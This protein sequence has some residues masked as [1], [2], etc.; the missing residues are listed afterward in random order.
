[1]GLIST[2]GQREREVKGGPQESSRVIRSQESVYA[3]ER[4]R[5]LR[6]VSAVKLTSLA[7]V[8]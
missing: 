5:E 6:A 7:F 3:K 8:P 1:M 4:V 2:H